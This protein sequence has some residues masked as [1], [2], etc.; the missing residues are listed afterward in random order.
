M[1]KGENA[2]NQHFLLF[3]QCFLPYQGYKSSFSTKSILSSA[4]AFNFNWSNILSFGK[5]F[6]QGQIGPK[7]LNPP[8]PL[9]FEYWWSDNSLAALQSCP[10]NTFYVFHLNSQFYE[11]ILSKFLSSKCNRKCAAR[12]LTLELVGKSK[13]HP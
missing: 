12:M 8:P 7:R 10:S 11:N 13:W 5:E 9:N 3:P 2:G 1:G 6:N 4:N